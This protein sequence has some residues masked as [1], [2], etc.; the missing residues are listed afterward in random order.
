MSWANELTEKMR[1]SL[2]HDA[3]TWDARL[4]A[5]DC[6]EREREA[7]R[8]WYKE[9]AENQHTFDAL[10][11]LLCSLRSARDAPEI[12]SIRESA[13]D[14]AFRHPPSGR[15]ICGLISPAVAAVG[16][17]ALA[18]GYAGWRPKQ[19]VPEETAPI[20]ATAVGERST[21]RLEDGSVAVLNTDT[22]IDVAFSNAERQVR[23]L[24]GQAL[25]EV[26]KDQDRPFVVL[27]G[28]QRIRAVGTV[29][30]VRYDGNKVQV[31]LVEG[32][33]DVESDA[34]LANKLIGQ[35]RS[36]PVRLTAGQTLKTSAIAAPAEPVIEMADVERATIWREGR[37][38]FDDAPLSDAVAEMNRYSAVKI[39]LDTE[40][41][42]RFR[43]NGMFRTGRQ[44]NF[45]EAI[46]A[47]FPVV[48]EHESQKRIVLRE[49][50]EL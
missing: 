12:R 27:A 30:E 9:S 25:F 10:Q 49:V 46:S 24:R 23:L 3:A 29:F 28:K 36:E 7:F 42:D 34:S 35:P 17:L 38:F 6:S 4:R 43:V 14:R 47:Y 32:V 16:F 31:T 11:D 2:P 41:L 44:G 21:T 20:L 37:V 26:A 19:H 45:V 13:F 1:Q 50:R 5:P 40:D 18:L 48:V 22:S 39:V 15:L 8:C 33:V